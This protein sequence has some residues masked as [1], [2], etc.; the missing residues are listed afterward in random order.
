ME[1][2][3]SRRGRGRENGMQQCLMKRGVK[4][5]RNAV[6]R[7]KMNNQENVD[8]DNN[9]AAH[10]IDGNTTNETDENRDGLHRQSTY[11]NDFQQ[12][13]GGTGDVYDIDSE[14]DISIVHDETETLLYP[15]PDILV[16]DMHPVPS[17]GL[18]RV[19]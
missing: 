3:M 10:S 13:S 2:L 17:T 19:Q 18:S 7:Y 1:I 14:E 12:L 5:T 6:K 4:E 15:F 16:L 9:M 8:L 11:N